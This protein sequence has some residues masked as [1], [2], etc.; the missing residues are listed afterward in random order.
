MRPRKT[1]KRPGLTAAMMKARYEF[2][3]KYE[4]WTIED[5]KRVI[6]TDETSVCLGVRRGKIRVRRTPEEIYDP[7]VIRRRYAGYS[8]YMFWG[9]F[10]WYRKGPCHIWQPESEAEKKAAQE[11]LKR[12]NALY[13]PIAKETWELGYSMRRLE[14]RSLPGRK[15][16]WRWNETNGL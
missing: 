13:E 5:W 4:H 8:E 16:V 12:L 10:S 2:A 9:S 1:T 7:T 14:L 6:W 15:P 3:L 11:E